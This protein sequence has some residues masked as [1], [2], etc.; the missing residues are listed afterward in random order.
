MASEVLGLHHLCLRRQSSGTHPLSHTGVVYTAVLQ[1]EN[2]LELEDLQVIHGLQLQS[3]WR[4]PTAAV[5]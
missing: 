2:E 4:I 5:S 3:L 1:V